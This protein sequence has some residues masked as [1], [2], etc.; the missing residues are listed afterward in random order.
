VDSLA[1]T[2]PTTNTRPIAY[3][4]SG[5]ATY[6]T[7]YKVTMTASS[8]VNAAF[9]YAYTGVNNGLSAPFAAASGLRGGDSCT[10][11]GTGTEMDC[12]IGPI[13][14][15]ATV[16]FTLLVPSPL[17]P[18]SNA[19]SLLSLTWA[20]QAGQGQPNPSN[21]VHQ[22]AQDVTLHV[23]TAAD[24]VQSYVTSGS[25]GVTDNNSTTNVTPPQAVTV[26]LKQT[27]VLSSCTSHF[28]QCLSSTVRIVDDS[29]APIQFSGTN[30]LVID[31]VRAASTLKKNAKIAN[32]TLS[33]TEVLPDGSLGASYD[34]QSC[35]NGPAWQIPSGQ[36]RCVVPALRNATTLTYQ[37]AAG[38]WHFHIIALTNGIIN[39]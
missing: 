10:P 16:S 32:A 39:W 9:F 2:D 4:V 33:Y 38:N 26:G 28:N 35:I 29:G 20:V 5:G 12:A 19:D 23:G 21:L 24:G 27:I 1:P 15:G 11:V 34:I 31:L 18:S 8:P 36:S 22:G 13:A 17:P 14:A 37:D 6:Q 7:A 25:L 3:S 30:P